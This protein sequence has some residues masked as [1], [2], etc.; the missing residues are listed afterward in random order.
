MDASTVEQLLED[1]PE[2]DHVCLFDLATGNRPLVAH[3]RGEPDRATL[4]GRVIAQ[5]DLSLA[6]PV[7]DGDQCQ[8]VTSGQAGLSILMTCA[9]GCHL[10]VAIAPR[11]SDL[12]K[13]LY[14][15]RGFTGLELE[16][17][18]VPRHGEQRCPFRTDA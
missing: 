7:L 16:I 2:I 13:V 14:V 18:G 3:R 15:L 11:P 1:L 10:L 8:L 17:L 4:A 12:G 5:R 6:A 9:A